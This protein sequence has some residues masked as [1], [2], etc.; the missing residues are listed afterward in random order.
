MTLA[1][2]VL[3][4]L[5]LLRFKTRKIPNAAMT[6]TVGIVN[7][8][9]YGDWRIDTVTGDDDGKLSNHRLIMDLVYERLLQ[10]SH[11]VSR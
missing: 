8:G 5:C 4:L 6:T 3:L 11:L 2:I 10:I 9:A 7:I 1:D